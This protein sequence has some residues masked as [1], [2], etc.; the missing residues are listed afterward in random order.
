MI[1]QKSLLDMNSVAIV[2]ESL[3]QNTLKYSLHSLN[4]ASF[5]QEVKYAIKF[6]QTYLPMTFKTSGSKCHCLATEN[7]DLNGLNT[8]L[9]EDK[10]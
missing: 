5:I 7:V 1:T 10:T 2:A 3:I 8:S 6:I 9:L 4:L